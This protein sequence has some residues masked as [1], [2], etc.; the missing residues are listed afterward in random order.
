MTLSARSNLKIDKEITP[1]MAY[2]PKYQQMSES[3]MVK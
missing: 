3:I 1:I 2:R